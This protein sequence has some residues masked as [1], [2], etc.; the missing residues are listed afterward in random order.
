MRMKSML[1]AAPRTFEVRE[2]PEPEIAGAGWIKVRHEAS[3]VCGSDIAYW[4]GDKPFQD[5]PL[6]PG[7]PIHECCGEVI[8]STSGMFSPGDRVV[9][10]PHADRGLAERFVCEENDAVRVPRERAGDDA[11]VLIQPLCTVLRA[12][13]RLGA[14][15]GLRTIVLGAGPIGLMA[16]WLLKDRG[17]GPLLAVDP[18]R[19]R[20]DAAVRLGADQ[21]LVA[22][23]TQARTMLRSGMLDF[24]EADLAVEA[25][26]HA[27]APVNDAI[28]LTRREGTLLALGV[29][30]D[31]VYALEYDALFR[32][33][34]NFIASVTPD[35]RTYLDKAA[36]LYA[37]RGGEIEF[38]VTHR[39]PLERAGEAFA[40][41]EDR[42]DGCIKVLI[43]A[44]DF[45]G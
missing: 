16:V 12:V 44:R 3:V 31:K 13:D 36:A 28:H 39:L 10:M 41:A 35:W 18:V 20:L 19:E 21:T 15:D 17:A 9:A 14:A 2:A 42:A 38:M 24:G 23:S 26:G 32:K 33:N 27:Q 11:A 40:L 22:S 43:D 37:R 7:R 29:P 25:V 8:E 30:D 45:G 1:L 34:L 6:E 4:R 5:F